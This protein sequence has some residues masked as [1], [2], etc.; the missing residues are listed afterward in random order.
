MRFASSRSIAA[1]SVSSVWWMLE[2]SLM[3]F[4]KGARTEIVLTTPSGCHV[5][6]ADLSFPQLT[7]A[8]MKVSGVACMGWFTVPLPPP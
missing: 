5:V 6:T 4:R 1:T 7:D 2:D 8:P 3:V